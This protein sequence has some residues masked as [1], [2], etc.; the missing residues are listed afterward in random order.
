MASQ[1]VDPLLHHLFVGLVNAD[2]I[3][4]P[5]LGKLPSRKM[6]WE[7]LKIG[8]LSIVTLGLCRGYKKQMGV[9]IRDRIPFP[10]E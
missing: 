2:N 9:S 4:R 8:A 3:L 1:S 7:L 10:L 6:A 5:G